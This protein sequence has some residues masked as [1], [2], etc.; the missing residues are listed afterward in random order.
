MKRCGVAIVHPMGDFGISAYCHQAAEALGSQGVGVEL[1]TVPAPV[2]LD[3]PTPRNYTLSTLLGSAIFKQPR[4]GWPPAAF[5]RPKG[6]A[7]PGDGGASAKLGRKRHARELVLAAE[8]ALE[9]RRRGH[10]VVWTQWFEVANY[11]PWFRSICRDVGLRLIHSVHNVLPHEGNA[12]EALQHGAAYRQSDRLIVHSE[13][14]LCDLARHFPECAGR[15]VV[16]RM[17]IDTMLPRDPAARR[18]V[19]QQLGIPDE[20]TAVLFPGAVRPYKNIDALLE[21]MATPACGEMVLVVAGRESGYEGWPPGDLC[22]TR[23]MARRA[24]LTD[25]LRLVTGPFSSQEMAGFY[26]MADVVAMPYVQG[27]GSGVLLSAMAAAA[28]V[29]ATPVGGAEEY[30]SQ[31]PASRILASADAKEIAAGLAEARER[32]RSGSLVRKPASSPNWD[33]FAQVVKGLVE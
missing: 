10:G 24:G 30:L 23:E 15:A 7:V 6:G 29:L 3:F 14:A 18:C 28:F 16:A 26:E 17:G 5:T 11:G 21:A 32:L 20:E 1:F 9:I 2:W 13:S 33:E 31:Y 22:R 12:E 19:R 25:R 4:N 8:L 27:F